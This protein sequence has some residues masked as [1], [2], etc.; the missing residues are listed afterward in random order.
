[1]PVLTHFLVPSYCQSVSLHGV[2]NVLAWTTFFICG[3]VPFIASR[4][5]GSPLVHG[6]VG[7][8]DAL[9]ARV[10]FWFTGHSIVYF[11]L[12]PAY[13]S[14]YTPREAFRS[15]AAELKGR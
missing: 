3:F 9:L 11:W 8:T 13:I 10:L 6:L 1:V 14:W 5:L 4:A 12:L 15:F 2:L 7:G